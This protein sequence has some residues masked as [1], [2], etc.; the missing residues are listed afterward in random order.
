MSERDPE[1]VSLLLLELGRHLGALEL[2]DVEQGRRALHA[3]KGSAGLAGELELA[4]ALARLEKRPHEVET[5]RAAAQLVKQAQTRLAA[6]LPAIAATWPEPPPHLV[7]CEIAPEFRAQYLAET[8]DRLAAIDATLQEL[9]LSDADPDEAVRTVYRHLHTIKGSAS[10]VGDEPMAWFCHGLEE[11]V[12]GASGPDAPRALAEVSRWRTT[13]G[14]MLD[15]PNAALH[16]LRGAPRARQSNVPRSTRP[17]AD[18]LRQSMASEDTIRV[19]ALAVDRTIERLSGATRGVEALSGAA[20]ERER[21]DLARTLRSELRTALRLIGPPRPWG[22]PAAAIRRVDGVAN[23]LGALAEALDTASNTHRAT[24]QNVREDLG[25]IRRELVAMREAKLKN[26]FARMAAAI[27]VEARR[28]GREV[29]VR[30]SGAEETIDRRVAEQLSEPCLQLARNAVAHGIEAPAARAAKGKTTAG[31]IAIT[32]RKL[33]TRLRLTIEDDGGGV[34][35]GALRAAAITRGAV[36]AEVADSADDDTLLGLL[37]LPG[38]SL[39]ETTDVLAG[40]GIG[41][42]IVLASVQRM[43]GVIHVSSTQGQGF[44]VEVEVPI[45][46]GLARVVWVRAGG[47]SYGLFA[48]HVRRVHATG[49]GASA[50]LLACLDPRASNADAPRAVDL[51]IVGPDVRL[52]VDAVGQPVPELVRPPTPLVAALGPFVGVV[53]REGTTPA[54]VLDA[55]TVASRARALASA[56][57]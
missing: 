26:L 8:A 45:E 6:G 41:L 38:F 47:A 24:E 51:D 53:A 1:L 42:D 39:R 19:A 48:S 30:T 21:A 40:R 5:F 2:G 20:R 3:L 33:G 25:A 27:E 46:T 57:A 18:D 50:A 10:S 13:L 32:A 12:R 31:T 9:S 11:R 54:F 15:D 17:D 22:A 49:E 56:R 4:A 43:A 55:Y 14:A 35:V 29:V 52:G 44:R 36:S 34:D 37:F 23:A 28:S 16:T 7:A